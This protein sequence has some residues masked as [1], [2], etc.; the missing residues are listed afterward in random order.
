MESVVL[1]VV[2]G[3][4]TAI[5]ITSDHGRQ[6]EKKEKHYKVKMHDLVNLTSL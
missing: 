5:Q 4:G 6:F 3:T 1:C 2:E